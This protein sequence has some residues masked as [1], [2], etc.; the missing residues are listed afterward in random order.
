[1]AHTCG[2]CSCGCSFYYAEDTEGNYVPVRTA[3]K[4]YGARRISR[5]RS[6]YRHDCRSW[7]VSTKAKKQWARHTH[8][9]V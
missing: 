5:S 7:K 3:S 1:M 9:L 2:I 8:R 4:F 6:T